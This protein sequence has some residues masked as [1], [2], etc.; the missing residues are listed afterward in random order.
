MIVNEPKNCSKPERFLE[1]LLEYMF[2]K[3]NIIRGFRPDWL[4]NQ[5]TG[6]NLEIDFY[7]SKP[8]S[9]GIEYQGYQHFFES[10]FGG[11]D[12]RQYKDD[13]K[14][15]L[16]KKRKIA[17]IEIFE[18]EYQQM[19]ALSQKEASKYLYRLV[20]SRTNGYYFRNFDKQYKKQ[21]KYEYK[22]YINDSRYLNE[23]RKEYLYN[24]F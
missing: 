9:I 24:A 2:P 16:C 5:R 1:D 11:L 17:L 4:K 3:I 19:N 6:K 22:L 23:L 10:K 14:R 18:I 7:L 12:Y 20:K 15:K 13:L 21:K 8:I